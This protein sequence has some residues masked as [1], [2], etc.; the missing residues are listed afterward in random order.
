MAQES[1][2]HRLAK[3]GY[4]VVHAAN[5]GRMVRR[6]N[7]V[8]QNATDEE[9][10]RLSDGSAGIDQLLQEREAQTPGTER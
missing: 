10:A 3:L 4:E 1:F 8:L 2:E 9:L 6:G 7:L 5:G